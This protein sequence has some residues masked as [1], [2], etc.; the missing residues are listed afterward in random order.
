MLEV[1]DPCKPQMIG[2]KT[3]RTSCRS[4]KDGLTV[5]DGETG[6]MVGGYDGRKEKDDYIG[7]DNP[8]VL[9]SSQKL[10]AGCADFVLVQD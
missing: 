7:G 5:H 8:I 9:N 1:W 4:T 2:H 6:K 10:R 3:N